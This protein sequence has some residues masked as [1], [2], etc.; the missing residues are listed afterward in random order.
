MK[1]FTSVITTKCLSSLSFFQHINGTAKIAYK[2]AAEESM[3]TAAKEVPQI[4]I[5]KDI[6]CTRVS[7]D[8]SWQKRGHSSLHGIVTAYWHWKSRYCYGCRMWEWKKETPE[9]QIW[10]L[11]HHCQINHVT[12]SGAMESAG[13]VDMFSR[14]V[15]KNNLIYKEYLGDGDTSSFDDVV[16]SKPYAE[17]NVVPVKL[18]CVGIGHVQKRLG[19]LRNLVKAHKGFIRQ[20][21]IDW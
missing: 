11:D 18:E 15:S 21:K 17:Q 14:S 8:G 7:I 3:K 10:K 20:R 19:S 1:T 13:A 2:N 5:V 9:Y 4:D 12:S 6:P 16:E